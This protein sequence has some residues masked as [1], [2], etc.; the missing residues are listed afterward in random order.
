M[1][2]NIDNSKF[3]KSKLKELILKLHKGGTQESVRQELLQ[4][5]SN[6]PY[7]EVVEV[8]QELISEGLPEEEVLKLCDAHSAVLHGAVDLSTSKSIPEGHPV[9]VMLQENKMLKRLSD[10]TT[11]E[12]LTIK[13]R[14]GE[15]FKQAVLKIR[16]AFNQLMDVDKHYQRKEYLLFPYLEKVGITGPPKVMWGKHD[17][18]REQLKGSIEILQLDEIESEDL[19]ASAEIILLPALK[20][21]YEMTIKEEEI[22]FPMMMD[23]L[24]DADWYEIQKQSLEIGYCLYDPPIEWKPE[25]IET[26]NIIEAQKAGGNIQLPTGN[27]SVEELLAILNTIPVDMTF[28]D[29]ND[30]VKY[31]TQSKDRIFQRNRAILNR[32]VRHCHPPASAHIVDK[33]L[34]DFKSGKQNRAPF[35]INMGG[36]FIHIEYFALR[37]DTGEYLGTLEVSRDLSND[38]KLEGEQRILSYK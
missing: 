8:E 28:V 17:E 3:R 27:F 36:R 14:K 19:T 22:L 20:G 9:D 25:G 15:D 18:I 5:L 37:N 6:I 21:V 2:E 1:S 23:T 35:W 12:L 31:F 13:Y 11:E 34:E 26:E 16:G 30:K 24:A 10:N 7:G 29:R 32:D 38:R 33:I 4:N